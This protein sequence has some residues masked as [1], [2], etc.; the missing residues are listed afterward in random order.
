MKKAVL[1][2]VAAATILGSHAVYA[3]NRAP[4]PP[5]MT[6][7]DR[8]AFLDARMASIKAGLQLTADQE[9]LWPP[10]E[11]A[12]RDFAKQRA[13][14]RDARISERD[15]RRA[16]RRQQQQ[17][18]G[19]NAIRTPR[20]PVARLRSEADSM[21][22][23]AAGLK[24]I[25]DATEPLYKTLNDSQKRRFSALTRLGGGGDWFGRGFERSRD[26][27]R[28]DRNRGRHHRGWRGDRG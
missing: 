12:L 15:A 10:V 16:E 24:K 2:A 19:D 22:T 21:T 14:E 20:D 1:A 5:R 23:T 8:A 9:K 25:A 3:Q 27:D 13:A 17:N 11:T 6:T 18:A 26:G 4:Q 28:P 7:E